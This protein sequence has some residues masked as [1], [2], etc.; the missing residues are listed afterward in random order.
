MYGIIPNAKTDALEKAPP[1]NWL[2]IAAIPCASPAV[3][4]RISELIPGS[5]I[6]E[7]IL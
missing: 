3:A 5:T 7:P 1:A 4:A 6:K 2:I